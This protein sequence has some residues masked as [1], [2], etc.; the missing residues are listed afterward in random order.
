MYEEEKSIV[1]EAFNYFKEKTLN[2]RKKRE[3]LLFLLI[4]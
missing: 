4:N 3:V 1:D 2:T